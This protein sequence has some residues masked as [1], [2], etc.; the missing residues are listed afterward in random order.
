ML[1]N[2]DSVQDLWGIVIILILLFT[3]L[4]ITLGHEKFK[5]IKVIPL[6][7][8]LILVGFFLGGGGLYDVPPEITTGLPNLS[9]DEGAA[10]GS[11][12]FRWAS[13]I[14]STFLMFFAGFSI[15][16]HLFKKYGLPSVLISFVP[17]LVEGTI[18]GLLLLPLLGPQDDG[19]FNW[20]IPFFI[21]Y[22][23]AAASPGIIVPLL[24]RYGQMGYGKHN[25]INEIA[26]IGASV[27]DVTS[28]GL[29]LVLFSLL[30]GVQTGNTDVGSTLTILFGRVPLMII[31]SVILGFIGFA[32]FYYLI[33]KPLDKFIPSYEVEIAGKKRKLNNIIVLISSILLIIGFNEFCEWTEQVSLGAIGIGGEKSGPEVWAFT[34]GFILV[35]TFAILVS[36]AY[37]K[38]AEKGKNQEQLQTIAKWNSLTWSF[39]F[40]PL[41]FGNIGGLITVNRIID[42]N[43]LIYMAVI[44]FSVVVGRGIGGTISLYDNK[45]FKW[46]DRAVVV[47]ASYPKGTSPAA[48]LAFLM[49]LISFTPPEIQPDLEK[50]LFLPFFDMCVAAIIITIPTGEP[51]IRWHYKKN[52]VITEEDQ[53]S[54]IVPIPLLSK[55]SGK[56]K[57]TKNDF[58]DQ[59]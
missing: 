35:L 56:N 45:K 54:P 28:L 8:L 9:V 7:L 40:A 50:Y 27:D 46:N 53:E 5:K 20:A 43:T 51:I 26:T 58:K 6:S 3:G 11:D 52:M 15:D 22:G 14:G 31:L 17:L 25:K 34:N 33:K 1:S 18:M 10:Y 38:D 23:M 32:I 21:G 2:L 4:I 13:L 16:F 44:V 47:A 41:V 49:L 12:F 36:T 19:L 24:V 29:I 42:W 59:K 30:V 37:R 57:K 39:L 48:S 55:F